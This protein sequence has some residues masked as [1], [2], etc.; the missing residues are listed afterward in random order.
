MQTGDKPTE[1]WEL[2]KAK[3]NLKLD[4]EQFKRKTSN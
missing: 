3:A 1:E 4:D 2:K